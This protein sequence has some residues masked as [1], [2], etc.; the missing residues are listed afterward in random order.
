MRYMVIFTNEPEEEVNVHL[1]DPFWTL[2]LTAQNT[3]DARHKAWRTVNRN[4]RLR[5]IKQNGWRI[6]HVGRPEEVKA[7]GP[8]RG[9]GM[10]IA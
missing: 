6:C 4:P 8:W 7:A 5:F 1:A 9:P 10:S 3:K 2:K